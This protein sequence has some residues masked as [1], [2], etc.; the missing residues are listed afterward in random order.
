MKKAV[1]GAWL[2]A[3]LLS[4]LPSTLH[5][6][7]TG[8]DVLEATRAAGM[9]LLPSETRDLPLLLAAAVVHPAISLFWAMALALVLPRRGLMLWALAASVMIAVV[10]LKIIAP[11]LFPAVAELPFWPQFADHLMWGACYGAVL[12][13]CLRTSVAAHD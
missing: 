6:L 10:D 9:M 4:G 5:A 7:A 1:F 12:S 3:T 11:M 2:A 13:R 8:G